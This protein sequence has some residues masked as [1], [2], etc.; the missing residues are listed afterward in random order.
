MQCRAA[1]GFRNFASAV[2]TSGRHPRRLD[3]ASHHGSARICRRVPRAPVSA[4]YCAAFG[5]K[6]ACQ[7]CNFHQGWRRRWRRHCR[8]CCHQATHWL[9]LEPSAGSSVKSLRCK[10]GSQPRRKRL[11]RFERSCGFNV[12]RRGKHFGGW[13]GEQGS[14]LGLGAS[15]VPCRLDSQLNS[16]PLV[17]FLVRV[18]LIVDRDGFPDSAATSAR[19]SAEAGGSAT[20]RHSRTSGKAAGR[21]GRRAGMLCVTDYRNGFARLPQPGKTPVLPTPAARAAAQLCACRRSRV[22]R[23]LEWTHTACL[24]QTAGP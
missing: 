4:S 24:M 9:L 8:R 3:C 6:L 11:C 18:S 15:D 13:S 21:A 14:M 22:T 23:F 2:S 5:N 20:C 12:D 17:A 10:S 16:A 19:R 1:A 7:A